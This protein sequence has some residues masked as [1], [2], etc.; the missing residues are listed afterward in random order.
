MKKTVSLPPLADVVI[1]IDKG[2]RPNGQV[3]VASP[4]V[5][6]RAKG[7]TKKKKP[8]KWTHELAAELVYHLMDADQENMVVFLLDGDRRLIGIY[9]H[10]LGGTSNTVVDAYHVLKMALLVGASEVV[11]THNHPSGR[12]SPSQGDFEATKEAS[13]LL[14]AWGIRLIEHIVVGDGQATYI[15]W[16]DRAF[17][18]DFVGSLALECLA[19][20]ADP[21]SMVPRGFGRPFGK[22][23]VWLVQA[24]LVRAPMLRS[25]VGGAGSLQSSMH[26]LRY[27]SFAAREMGTQGHSLRDV[28]L[29]ITV[30]RGLVPTSVSWAEGILKNGSTVSAAVEEALLTALLSGGVG[31]FVVRVNPSGG[32]RMAWDSQ[33]RRLE[34]EWGGRVGTMGITLLDYLVVDTAEEKVLYDT[35]LQERSRQ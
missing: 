24:G 8:P 4:L 23:E 34:N 6:V 31:A 7:W 9:C 12:S 16:K 30:N 17:R 26:V 1:D 15:V 19:A 2:M 32:D 28:F 25:R 27:A 13:L 5:L 11:L 20:E 21:E 22:Y 10:S 14:E 29:T 33:R 35:P 3:L 18:E